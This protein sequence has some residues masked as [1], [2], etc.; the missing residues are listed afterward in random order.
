MYW[1]RC[2]SF[3]SW[4]LSMTMSSHEHAE[5]MN[6]V[7]SV[8]NIKSLILFMMANISFW[9]AFC[10]KSLIISSFWFAFCYKSLIISFAN[11]NQII[12][13]VNSSFEI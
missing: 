4:T 13:I 10:Y 12:L 5:R 6:P 2:T 3:C 8:R 11:L 1:V 9:F 7:S